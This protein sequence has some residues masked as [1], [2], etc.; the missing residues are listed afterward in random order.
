MSNRIA[1]FTEMVNQ[2]VD[3]DTCVTRT[4]YVVRSAD[5]R[6]LCMRRLCLRHLKAKS[7]RKED[8]MTRRVEEDIVILDCRTKRPPTIFLAD[9]KDPGS[10]CCRSLYL[11]S[12]SCGSS[13]NI[14]ESRRKAG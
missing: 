12:I 6:S 13:T 1:S 4:Y 8:V 14:P 9:A 3:F 2:K 10:W 11:G 7:Q 5:V